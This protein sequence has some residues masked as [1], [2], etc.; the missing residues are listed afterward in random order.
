[1][2]RREQLLNYYYLFSNFSQSKSSSVSVNCAHLH[3]H[4]GN[5]TPEDVLKEMKEEEEKGEVDLN[6]QEYAKKRLLARQSP[7]PTVVLEVRA[8]PTP[9]FRARP[10][11]PAKLP[12]NAE[13]P[14]DDE[15]DDVTGDHKELLQ[16]D[17]T[18]ADIQKLEA[19]FGNPAVTEKNVLEEG[20]KASADD[21][22]Y[23]AIGKTMGEIS[24]V[25]HMQ[26]AQEWVLEH[27]DKCSTTTSAFTE[28]DTTEIDHGYEF[29]FTNMAMQKQQA[30][31]DK[32]PGTR[33]QYLVMPH[34]L[35]SSATS[36]EK[37][38][39]EVKNI[40]S[41]LPDIRDHANVSIFHP[42]HVIEE[43]RSPMPIIC[44][45]WTQDDCL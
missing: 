36:L 19:L 13:V 31:V 8:Q 25:S 1:M 18:S 28:S 39:T 41:T 42:E 12:V 10:A 43:R 44:L 5:K 24:S 21:G 3:P 4:F 27:D 6:A 22:F 45:H 7:Y 34:F 32:I 37:F 29:V 11:P 14:V 23:D 33:R 35:S 20:K 26:R 15:D 17:V 2:H 38:T 16:K 30:S 40:V 9:D